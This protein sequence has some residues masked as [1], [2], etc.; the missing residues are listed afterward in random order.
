MK[1]LLPLM[2]SLLICLT[3]E[4]GS[5]QRRVELTAQ[6]I[7]GRVDN[8]LNYPSGLMKGTMIHV[9]PTG[10]SYTI[11]ITAS[12]TDTDFLFEIGQDQKTPQ[13]KVLYNF[14]GDDIWVYN[15]RDVKLHHKVGTGKYDSVLQTN[16]SYI[17]LSNAD[18]QSNYSATIK[19]DSY[20][21]KQDAYKLRLKPL[22]VKGM[23]GELTLYVSKR[24]FSPLR[25]DYNDRD[26]VIF[27][28]LNI[29]TKKE[30]SKVLP[31][32]YEMLDIKKGTI[33][34]L[35]FWQF[36]RKITFDK[37]IFRHQNLVEKR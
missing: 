18:F 8:I 7:L 33:T 21:M 35:N 31:V 12:V 30:G 26:M 28:T 10:K 27:K 23:Y 6:E 1:S 32:K 3:A 22:D 2:L 25:I 36:D 19:G 14:S 29:T 4:E 16:F 20:L 5:S 24:D 34:V 13:I 11:Y 37:R 17:D 9:L 15:T